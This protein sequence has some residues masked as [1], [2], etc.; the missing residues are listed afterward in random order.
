MEQ[1]AELKPVTIQLKEAP[2]FMIPGKIHLT[3]ENPG[4]VELDPSKLTETEKAWVNNAHF[5]RKVH[6][7]NPN[8]PSEKKAAVQQ[9]KP[10]PKDQEPSMF[11]DR[12]A[13]VEKIKKLLKMPLNSLKKEMENTENIKVLRMVKEQEEARKKPRK[14]LLKIVDEKLKAVEATVLERVGGSDVGDKL[15]PVR[16]G[17]MNSEF[18][19]EI[20]DVEERTVVVRPATEDDFKEGFEVTDE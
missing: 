11:K 18:V 20:T 7:E 19:S 1:A 14:S 13:E 16:V 17:Q 8:G 10:E 12:D 2:L 6:V 5:Q 15:N 3:T 9:P 4:P